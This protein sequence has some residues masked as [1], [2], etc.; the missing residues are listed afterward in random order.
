MHSLAINFSKTFISTDLFLFF[1]F[2]ARSI[3]IVVSSQVLICILS[4]LSRLEKY[5]SS[6][7]VIV[8]SFNFYLIP[9]IQTKY[10]F[11]VGL[12]YIFC[13]IFYLNCWPLLFCVMPTI[14]ASFSSLVS[15]LCVFITTMICIPSLMMGSAPLFRML[16][17][18]PMPCTFQRWTLPTTALTS[19]AAWSRPWRLAT[20][21]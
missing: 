14:W 5:Q 20:R 6:A 16:S 10:V 12:L 3:L 4:I 17:T 21:G 13:Q 15:R 9:C 2:R 11:E 7:I 8:M 19:T 1:V 18:R